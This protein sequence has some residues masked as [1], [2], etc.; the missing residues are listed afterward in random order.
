[1]WNS[2]SLV[3]L[4]IVCVDRV[5]LAAGP[6]PDVRAELVRVAA[7]VAGPRQAADA[8]VLLDD[9]DVVALF[10]EVVG[11]R[12]SGHA[13]AQ[14]QNLLVHDTPA[15]AAPRTEITERTVNHRA[16]E[17]R[18]LNGGKQRFDGSVCERRPLRN[19]IGSRKTST[20]HIQWCSF[21]PR[22]RVRDRPCD[23]G[24]ARR[25]AASRLASVQS[26]LL[27]G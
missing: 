18:R 13:A 14:D 1:M 9:G 17:K 21:S 19:R 6:E 24:R 23:A 12:R 20:D 27:C 25:T 7:V 16:T 3:S 22:I 15:L 4:T 10:R 26:P 11:H 5:V 2:S 8:A